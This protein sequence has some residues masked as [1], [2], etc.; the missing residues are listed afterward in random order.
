M[1]EEKHEAEYL[2]GGQGRTAD[3]IEQI[4]KIFILI[5]ASLAP[6]VWFVLILKFLLG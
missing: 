6:W 3:W 5:I 4:G 2:R 1:D